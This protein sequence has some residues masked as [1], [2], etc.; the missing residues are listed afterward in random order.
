MIGTAAVIVDVSRRD[1]DPIGAIFVI[2][3]ARLFA[4][5]GLTFPVFFRMAVWCLTTESIALSAS[6]QIDAVGNPWGCLETRF[7]KSI[8]E[9]AF[10][11][12]S[13]A[14]LTTRLVNGDRLG[15]E[16]SENLAC[17]ARQDVPARSAERRYC[18]R[19][20]WTRAVWPDQD[21]LDKRWKLTGFERTV[22]GVVKNSGANVLTDGDSIEAYVPIEGPDLDRSALILHTPVIRR[23]WCALFRVSPQRS[24][25]RPRSRSRWR[26]SAGWRAELLTTST[27]C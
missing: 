15:A 11:S 27:T 23:R 3:P 24:M 18:G 1:R 21:P 26:L 5:L 6:T 2:G 14:K 12:G 4:L 25:K 13:Q 19:I 17:R 7:S 22:V 20:G 9:E 10:L 8:T 16:I